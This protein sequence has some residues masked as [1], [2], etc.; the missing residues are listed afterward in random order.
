MRSAPPMLVDEYRRLLIPAAL[1]A[2]KRL[3]VAPVDLQLTSIETV[4][5]AVLAR[6]DHTAH[7]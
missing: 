4:A 7:A 2:G 6:Y 3:L 5:Q 1:G